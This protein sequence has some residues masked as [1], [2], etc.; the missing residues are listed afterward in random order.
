MCVNI[1]IYLY[2]FLSRINNTRLSSRSRSFIFILLFFSVVWAIRILIK[3][4]LSSFSLSLSLHFVIEFSFLSA[5][6]MNL[7]ASTKSLALF[8][9]SFSISPAYGTGRLPYTKHHGSVQLVRTSFRKRWRIT[10][11]RRHRFAYFRPRLSTCACVR[12]DWMVLQSTGFMPS[13]E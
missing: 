9:T 12:E 8:T 13:L 3:S 11:R 7:A 2:L 10:S 4:F 1:Y 5:A 6:R